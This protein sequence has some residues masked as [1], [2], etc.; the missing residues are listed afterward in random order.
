MAKHPTVYIIAG[1]NGAGKTTFAMR[2]LPLIAGCRNFINADM[3]ASGLSPLNARAAVMQGGRLFLQQINRQIASSASFAFETTLSGRGHARLLQR[4]R[5]K[6]YR[7]HL[8]F[9]W[10]PNVQL[11]LKRIADRVRRGGHN[12][13]A[14]AVRRRYD[15]GLSNLFRRYMPL[16]DYCAMFDNSSE[17]PT[18]VFERQNGRE[19]ILSADVWRSIIKQ[20]ENIK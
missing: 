7:V 2:F 1:S 15:K 5:Q 16:T 19:T 6:G 8:Y 13:P 10:I 18:L 12:V 11:A 17:D 20:K 14:H 3:I 9:L 4:L